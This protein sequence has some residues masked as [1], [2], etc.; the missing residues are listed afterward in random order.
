M[1]KEEVQR[2]YKEKIL[3]E[4]KNPY[5]FE[6][7]DDAELI[8]EAYNPMCGDKYKLYIDF[9]DDKVRSVHFHGFGCAV[10]KASTSLL[11]RE[12]EGKEQKEIPGI[13]STF[14]GALR[15]KDQSKATN[16]NLKILVELMNFDGR[17]DCIELSWKALDKELHED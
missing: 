13:V 15:E 11:A 9:E 16:E 3:P 1:T 8:L 12:L 4:S 2:L 6:E 5:H 14:L 17:Q 10:S 7:Q